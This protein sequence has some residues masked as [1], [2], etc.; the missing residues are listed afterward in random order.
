LCDHLF[1]LSKEVIETGTGEV[2]KNMPEGGA[3]L[4]PN[5]SLRH[6]YCNKKSRAQE[7]ERPVG[8]RFAKIESAIAAHKIGGE[9]KGKKARLVF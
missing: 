3:N 7:L 6:G 9:K 2:S 1:V 8:R 4:S 5:S